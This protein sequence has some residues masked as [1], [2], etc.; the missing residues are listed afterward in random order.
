M[1]NKQPMLL[2]STSLLAGAR[3][4]SAIMPALVVQMLKRAS[5]HRALAVRR[6]D[7]PPDA[8]DIALS[9]MRGY[10]KEIKREMSQGAV[11]ELARRIIADHL[12]RAGCEREFLADRS[13]ESTTAARGSLG[14]ELWR[15]RESL[16]KEPS[17]R[18]NDSSIV[19]LR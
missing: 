14:L 6:S 13:R 9:T 18:L 3:S 16:C 7:A 4:V 8:S 15:S 10:F 2:A 5:L 19:I 11:E 12:E 1:P 17:R